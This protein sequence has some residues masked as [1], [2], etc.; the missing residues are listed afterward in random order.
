MQVFRE[1]L[2]KAIDHAREIQDRKTLI[3]LLQQREALKT[4]VPIK[5]RRS[6][7]DN[8]TD[9]F[10][11]TDLTKVT[12]LVI[13]HQND[14]NWC[15]DT[16]GLARYLFTKQINPYTRQPFDTADIKKVLFTASSD[17]QMIA[18]REKIKSKDHLVKYTNL[19]Y[20]NCETELMNDLIAF[21][22]KSLDL[23]RDGGQDYLYMLYLIF[24]A[25]HTEIPG[26]LNRCPAKY[27]LRV[28]AATRDFLDFILA[29]FPYTVSTDDY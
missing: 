27:P 21:N 5:Q 11:A 15:F 8:I 23:I 18:Q 4:S 16:V 24:N 1:D 12:N 20:T 22:N 2:Q 9:P 28:M 3:R 17:P 13:I 10:S 29:I 26:K 14:K 7:C 6:G 25:A 19:K